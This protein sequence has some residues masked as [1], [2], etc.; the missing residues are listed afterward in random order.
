MQIPKPLLESLKEAGRVLLLGFVAWLLTDGV[1]E[2]ILNWC[3]GTL[4]DPATKS[5]IISILFM[6]L[7]TV[8]KWLHEKG[9]EE[10]NDLLTLGLTRF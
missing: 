2:G 5:T 4:F 1:V 3:C 9:I 10:S 7:R 8:D 6:V